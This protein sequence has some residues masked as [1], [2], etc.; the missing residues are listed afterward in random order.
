MLV[1]EI[2]SQRLKEARKMRK[3]TQAELRKKSGCVPIGQFETGA[4]LPSVETV[5]KLASALNVSADYLLDMPIRTS[6]VEG[7]SSEQID[8]INCLIKH[9]RGNK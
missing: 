4:R 5:V 9:W 7:L 6:F 3:M 1:K 8:T 2:F